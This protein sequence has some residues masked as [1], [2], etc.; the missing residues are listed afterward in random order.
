MEAEENGNQ[1]ESSFESTA[2]AEARNHVAEEIRYLSDLLEPSL[3]F[4]PEGEETW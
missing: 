4:F 3:C 2:S 1:L